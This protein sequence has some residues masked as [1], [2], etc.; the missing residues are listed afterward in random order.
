L[1]SPKP[2]CS[3]PVTSA[4]PL[5]LGYYDVDF[6]PDSKERR[7]KGG[8]SSGGTPLSSQQKE[9]ENMGVWNSDE[10]HE[11]KEA[12]S[13]KRGTLIP[14]VSANHVGICT[15]QGRRQYQ[16]DRHLVSEQ[17]GKDLNLDLLLLAVFDGHG[18]P[19]CAQY[20][21]DNIQRFVSR[22]I[23]MQNTVNSGGGGG[24][25]SK[26][27]AG[28]QAK[29]R[30]VDISA[31]IS[32]AIVEMN[33]SFNRYWEDNRCDPERTDQTEC[34]NRLTSPGTTATVALIRDGYE[35]VVAQVGDS[36]ALLIR[37]SEAVCLT[38][39]HCASDVDERAR[40]ESRGG[41]VSYDEVGRHLVN[42]RLAM[43]RSI[44]DLEL[45]QF[46]VIPEPTIVRRNIKHWKDSC[47]VMVTDGVTF[48]MSNQEIANCLLHC[49]QPLE[50][51]EKLVDQALLHA[52]Q[53]NLTALVL[54]LGAWGNYHH[55]SSSAHSGATPMMNLGRNMALS[56]RFG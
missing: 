30:P 3:W 5:C 18:G 19:E 10:L 31:A 8:G 48:V 47:L 44:G 43:S 17:I 37:G 55:Q 33:D 4:R 35:L 50:S 45:K 25:T 6:D 54:P 41:F 34:H 11:I 26:S 24:K 20:C 53:D 39:D 56:S 36:R 14:K 32:G 16:E 46:G 7:R 27:E 12:P 1:T 13:V 49:D 21:A 52:C 2:R 38:E 15:S 23:A 40:I 42:K 9:F 51:A 22:H 29:D 28:E